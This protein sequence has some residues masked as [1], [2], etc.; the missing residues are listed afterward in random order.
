MNL[1]LQL[2]SAVVIVLLGFACLE[3][4]ARSRPRRRRNTGPS[5]R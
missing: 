4:S 3:R 1:P 5:S 2:A